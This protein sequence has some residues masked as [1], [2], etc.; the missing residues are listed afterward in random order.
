MALRDKLLADVQESEVEAV[1]AQGQA[2][3]EQQLQELTAQ[4]QD[5][6]AQREQEVGKLE[7]AVQQ[8][9]SQRQHDVE[10]L[11]AEVEQLQSQHEQELQDQQSKVTFL[12]VLP[13]DLIPSVYAPQQLSPESHGAPLDIAR[14]GF[15]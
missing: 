3:H 4:I 10:K 2:K 7:A 6:K 12:M 13:A 1:R 8:L 14:V 11:Q 15:D 5:M 9:Q